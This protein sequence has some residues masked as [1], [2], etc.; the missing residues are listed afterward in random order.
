VTADGRRPGSTSAVWRRLDWMLLL[1]VA[2]AAVARFWSLR[3][4]VW[5]DEYV[6]TG[7]IVKGS[8]LI[9]TLNHEEGTPPLY[10][11]ALWG[12]TKVFK[13]D[14]SALRTF[15]AII[16]TATVPVV[17]AAARELTASRRV[18]RI[19]A[20]LIA[21]NPMLVWFSQE[22][23]AYVLLVFVAA[24]SL[25]CWARAYMRGETR[26][27]VLWGVAAAAALSTHYFAAF[28]ILP[29]AVALAVVFRSH[30]R[31]VATGCAPIAATGLALYVFFYSPQRD[32]NLQ[33][34]LARAPLRPRVAEAGRQALI[35]PG[36]WDDRLWLG[37]AVLVVVAVVLVA[38][39]ADRR[40]R[41][42]AALM[43]VFG[44]MGVVLALAAAATGNDYFLGRNLVA[45]LVPLAIAVAIGFG[46]RRAGWTGIAAAAA[47][48][49]LTA[50]IVVTVDT[51][52]DLQKTDWR[53]L[54]AVL[55]ASS[56]DSLVV[57]DHD[58]HLAEPLLRYLKR[59]RLVGLDEGLPVTQ[60][61]LLYHV[62]KPINRCGLFQ[63]RVCDAGI[64]YF[65]TF[66]SGLS[67]DFLYSGKPRVAEFAVNVYRSG[68]PRV[69]TPRMLLHNPKEKG[70]VILRK[71]ASSR[72]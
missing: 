4:S 14:D 61:D 35:G 43:G 64:F 54:A 70:I 44:A 48:C 10:F 39:R 15:S 20:A 67:R 71:T 66:P 11:A 38:I 17:Y 69:V 18:A 50:G 21:V 45:E 31:R 52:A 24:V 57:V 7:V 42:A 28:L 62:P 56:R 60:I 6:T 9:K 65:P 46:A 49:A 26:D 47:L 1:L 13:A 2:V 36:G 32:A 29:E 12:W 40:E 63:G 58:G 34:W 22:A 30:W 19:A 23:R 8:K 59:A 25:W 51:K 33:R 68:A 5:F 27:F 3:Q 53:S 41:S 37:G 16:G 72:P 55:D